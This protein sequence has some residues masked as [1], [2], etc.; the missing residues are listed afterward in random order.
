MRWKCFAAS[1]TLQHKFKLISTWLK[2]G[3]SWMLQQ[4]NDLKS[5][6][7]LVVEWQSR[8]I[9]SLKQILC[10]KVRLVPGKNTDLSEIFLQLCYNYDYGYQLPSGHSETC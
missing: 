8:L 2:L 7:K 4:D 3:H 9:L 1:G 5:T 6:S 10:L